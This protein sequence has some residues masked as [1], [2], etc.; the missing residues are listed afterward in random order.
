MKRGTVA[1]R[2]LA[3]LGF[4]FSASVFLC[5]LFRPDLAGGLLFLLFPL[6][7]LA[8]ALLLRGPSR[9]ISA[10][11]GA[12]LLAGCLS[13]GLWERLVLEKAALLAGETRQVEA[14]V[15][16][17]PKETSY[18]ESVKAEVGRVRCQLYLDGESGLEPGARIALDAHFS[19]SQEKTGDDYYLSLGLPLFGYADSEPQLLGAARPAV[20]FFPAKLGERLRRNIR[21][22]VDGETAAFLTAI[23]TGERSELRKDTFFYSMMRE[24]G[25]LH[26]IAVSGM[27]LSFLVSFLAFALG[28]GK[29]SSLVCIPVILLF[30]AVTGFTASVVRAGIMQILVCVSVLLDREYDS[31]TALVL[32]LAL[33]SAANPY[34]LRNVGLVLSFA[35]TLGILLFSQELSQSLPRLSPERERKFPGVLLRYVRSSLAVSL[36]AQVLTLPVSAVAFGQIPLLAPLTN[37]LILWAVTISFGLGLLISILGFFWPLGASVAGWPA[38]VL[39]RYISA[40]V[41]TVGRLPFASLYPDNRMLALWLVLLYGLLLFFRFW[42]GLRRRLRP[43]LLAA[44]SSL[45]VCL[46]LGGLLYRQDDLLTGFLD[47]GQGQCVVLSG[48]DFALAADCGSLNSSENAGDVAARYLLSRGR[49]RLDALIL[50]HYDADHRNGALELLRR[51]KVGRLIVPPPGEDPFALEL[52]QEAEALGVPVDVVAEETA[53]IAFGKLRGVIVPPLG[54]GGGNEGGLCMLLSVGEFDVLLTGDASG[55]TEL[56]L[57]ERLELPDVELMAAGHHGSRNSSSRALL[58]AAAPD[59]AVISVGRNSYGLPSEDALR[60]LLDAG[61]VVY[62]TDRGGTVEIAYQERKGARKHG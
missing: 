43:C 14:V 20:R 51:M 18:G 41:K 29:R 31:P 53:E 52:L 46:C 38:R 28:R 6:P 56:R 47:V 55:K 60:R 19:L 11:L 9:R 13:F 61:A 5:V 48:R 49:T 17:Y 27:H 36:S 16:E 21:A 35:A 32:A 23:L 24:A 7:F 33:M 39:V 57:L 30:M 2:E 3:V 8:A 37:L 45:L 12:G 26:C 4:A 10:L 59:V 40:V 58:E 42:P 44:F 62:R 25:V 15:L 54:S 1:G 34:A 50:S 22:A